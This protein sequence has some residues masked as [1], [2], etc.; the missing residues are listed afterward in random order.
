MSRGGAV[1]VA[2][3]V[4]R[5]SAAAGDDVFTSDVTGD[6][7][8]RFVI[9]ANGLLEWGPGNA[10]LDTN[11]FREGASIL[12][13]ND[14]LVADNDMIARYGQSAAMLMGLAGPSSEAGLQFG[15]AGDTNLYRVAA[16][17]LQTDDVFRSDKAIIAE[18]GNAGQVALG[19]QGPANQAGIKFGSAAD[20]NL[21]RGA[22]DTLKTDDEFYAVGQVAAKN[23]AASQVLIGNL[24]PG[25]EAG[26]LFGSAGDTNLYRSAADTLSTS[27]AF[28]VGGN[29]LSV[30]GAFSLGKPSVYSGAG[31]GG[32]VLSFGNGAPVNANGSNG[33]I[34]MRSDGGAL[35]TIYQRRAG[36]WVGII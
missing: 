30:A 1:V 14:Y 10:A 20:T 17:E 19:Q 18:T 21:Y 13:T 7:N 2:N 27:D 11:L 6:T 32:G 26:A 8:D 15:L 4:D 33:D 36:A 35:T 5:T 3:R 23:G 28:T 16:D 24:G 34:Y 22:A 29:Y 25:G 31:N 9:N 12:R